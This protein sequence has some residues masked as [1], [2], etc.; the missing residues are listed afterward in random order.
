M[1]SPFLFSLLS[2]IILSQNI[3]FGQ[4]SQNGYDFGFGLAYPRFVSL[5]GTG[6]SGNNNFGGYISI[7]REFTEHMGLRIH[8]GVYHLES[9]YYT[10]NIANDQKVNAFTGDLDLIFNILPCESVSPFILAGGGFIGSKSSNSFNK[11]LND[12][13]AGYQINFGLGAYW[14]FSDAW[15]LKTEIDYHTLSHNKLDGNYS[16]NEQNKGI[17]GG[18]GDTYMR[19]EL[20]LVWQFSSGDKSTL[21]EKCPGGIKEIIKIDTIY[22]EI[23][24][25]VIR[26]EKDT[27]YLSKPMLFTVNFDFDKSSISVES[28]PILGHALNVLNDNPDIQ[29]LISGFTDN[30]GSDDYNQKLSEKRVNSIYEYLTSKGISSNRITKNAFGEK[31]PVR[32]NNSALN[33]AFNRRVEFKVINK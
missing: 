26:L 5:T 11:E 3:S 27:V 22:K 31:N 15:K 33:R 29:I 19:F 7:E 30:I 12:F 1:K 24:R 16:L 18:N 23:P 13:V 28:Y 17:L 6:Y 4:I 8:T 21:C 32:V 20:G 14:K 25:Q 2:I 10:G 9:F